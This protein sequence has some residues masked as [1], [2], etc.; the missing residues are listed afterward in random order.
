MNDFFLIR[1]VYKNRSVILTSLFIALVLGYFATRIM[2]VLSYNIELMNGETNNVWN[3]LNVLNGRS[4]Y[5][6][7]SEKPYE[8]FQY[9]PLSQ[10]LYIGI[11]KILNI[12]DLVGIYRVL[13]VL[14]LIINLF[15]SF[16]S[17]FLFKKTIKIRKD[18]CLW[19]SFLGLLLLTTQN[20][21][22]RPDALATLLTFIAV[23]VSYT[24]IY[25]NSFRYL[26]ISGF[27]TAV[28]V[29]CKQ[30]AIQLVFII[31]VAFLLLRKFKFGMYY[32]IIST[33]FILLLFYLFRFL[34]G[35]VFVVSVIG[36]LNNGISFLDAFSIV[37]YYFQ[38]YSI[39]PIIVITLALYVL[40]N[41]NDSNITYL[42]LL[43]FG[44]FVFA[45][46]TSLKPGAWINYFTM[47]NLT[48]VLFISS[49]LKVY[50]R[51]A[52]LKF[53]YLFFGFYFFT[54][55]FFHYI[56]PA[57]SFNNEEMVIKEKQ[58]NKI[59]DLMSSD[60]HLYTNDNSIKLFLFDKTI[61]PNHEY[62]G[63]SKFKYNNIREIKEHLYILYKD[64]IP[65]HVLDYVISL[66]EQEVKLFTQ[67]D[68]M[69]LFSIVGSND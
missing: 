48:G 18:I 43:V 39:Y 10:L 11:L 12:S 67:I 60:D 42:A 59:R 20:W 34:F 17:Y 31:P 26:S 40:F 35:D 69:K 4:L 7:P 68:S 24:A 28:A 23:G 61:F 64:N 3:I 25:K 56:T 8:I 1:Y 66:K 19:L 32:F 49:L 22:I 41:K 6:D 57:L 5:M 55:I 50:S 44:T 62:Y 37:N 14:N 21:V 47:F 53:L 27:I 54:G 36:G 52:L 58:S 16:Y 29:F 9:T 13:R 30:D 45:L 15:A 38:I 2:F 63:V 46:G 65:D 33:A 51:I